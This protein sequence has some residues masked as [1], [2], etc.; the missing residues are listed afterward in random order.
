MKQSSARDWKIGERGITADGELV[1]VIGITG[2]RYLTIA[3]D[4]D[5][6]VYIPAHGEIM[7]I[8]SPFHPDPDIIDPYDRL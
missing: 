8:D 7:K 6:R 3:E 2:G 4:L 5:K 1:T